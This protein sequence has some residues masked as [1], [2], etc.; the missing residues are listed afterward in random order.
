M[1]TVIA[2]VGRSNVGK[3]TFFNRVS[4]SRSA[5]VD[6]QP[7]ITRDR[8]SATV[9]V[10]GASFKL[11]DTGGFDDL[12]QDPLLDKVRDQV[13]I[14][15]SQADR[16]IFLVDGRQG[17]ISGDEEMAQ[18][19]RQSEKKVY[20]VANKIDGPEHDHL[21]SDFYQLGVEMVYPV[22]AAHG[23]GLK[24]LLD[25]IVK[26]LPE[27]VPEKDDANQV[28]IAVLGR[29]NAGKSSI[30][31]RI[32]G[33]DRVLVSEL[34]GTTRDTVDTLFKWKGKE[35]LLIDTAGIKRK[36]KVKDKIEKFSMIKAIES[37]HRCHVA[38]ILLDAGA[39]IAD[40]DVRICSYALERFR[41][42]V[43]GV[44]KWDLIKKDPYARKGLNKEIERKL[45]FA[46][47]IPRI[48]LSALTGDNVKRLFDK[49]DLV[50]NQFCQRVNTGLVNRA[51]EDMILKK[52]PHKVGQGRLKLFYAT[53][54]GIK[55]PTFVVFVNRP[56]AVHFSYK[57]FMVNQFRRKFGLDNTPIRLLFRK[58][59]G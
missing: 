39:G 40:Q 32:L 14:A 54:T 13:K 22:S 26:D 33:F 1:T 23:Y 20:T 19:L 15:I 25:D 11:I 8:I 5:L 17:I 41:G 48:N 2:I 44:N 29:P 49:V 34:P 12:G 3:S 18:I 53:Q 57:R 58:K 24:I 42:I 59:G 4:R 43:L 38:V 46:P 37:L 28:R 30:I 50:Y 56:D 36:G 6:D 45:N 31:N 47:F 27:A 52:P 51:V 10:G 21:A 35:Y 7:G 9:Q 55:P 16:I